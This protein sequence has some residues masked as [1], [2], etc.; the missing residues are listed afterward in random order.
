MQ[1]EPHRG[2]GGSGQGRPARGA[3]AEYRFICDADLSMPVGKSAGS[4]R[5]WPTGFDVAIGSREGQG[6]PASWRTRLPASGGPPLQLR[7]RSASCSRGSRIRSAASRCSPAGLSASIFPRVT[8]TGW[9]FDV[10]VL[11]IAR[12]RASA[13]LRCR[14]SGTTVKSQVKMMRDGLE[15]LRELVRIRTRVRRLR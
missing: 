4:C 1:R 10:E 9:A 14:S 13:W 12:A 15:M 2:K 11:T 7:G 5:R 6:R 3:A 8:V